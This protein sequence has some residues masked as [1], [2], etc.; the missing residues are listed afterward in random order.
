MYKIY[1]MEIKKDK[2][3]E[4]NWE[5]G[6]DQEV[7]L[8]LIAKGKIDVE[9]KEQ[10][11]YREVEKEINVEKKVYEQTVEGLNIQAVIEAVNK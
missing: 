9:K 3:R 6:F 10:Y 2:V 7:Y 1:I 5:R 11:E 8:Y 4:S